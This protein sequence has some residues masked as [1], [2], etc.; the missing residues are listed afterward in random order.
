MRMLPGFMVVLGLLF[1]AVVSSNADIKH[2]F[3]VGAHYWTTLENIDVDEVEEDGFAYLVSYQL[4]PASLIKFGLDVEMLPESFG[5]AE[6]P[7]F[8]P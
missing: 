5:G 8:A 2:R 1:S 3:G 4:R 6:D 7:V